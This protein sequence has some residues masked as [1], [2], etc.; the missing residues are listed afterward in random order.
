MN[1]DLPLMTLHSFRKLFKLQVS[2]AAKESDLSEY[3][4]G[5][6]RTLNQT[7]FKV[8]PA[9]VSKVYLNKIMEHLTF[10]DIASAEKAKEEL[11]Q[12]LIEERDANDRELRELKRRLSA[13]ENKLA[14]VVNRIGD[15][16]GQADPLKHN[17]CLEAVKSIQNR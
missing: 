8:S 6:R 7:Y 5:H 14:S 13:Y 4:L 16:L 2:L 9:D 11:N 17:E 3:L 10:C 1:S 15:I 12:K